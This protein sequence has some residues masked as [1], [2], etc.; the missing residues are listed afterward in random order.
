MSA[1]VLE[2]I[3]A[4]LATLERLV[5][6]PE[7]PFYYGRDLSCVTDITETLEEVD[8]ASPVAVVQAVA[9]RYLTER[10]SLPDDPNYGF[11][12][13]GFLNRATPVRELSDVAG[14]ARLEALKDD[15]V[16]DA[17]VVV[18]MP[19]TSEIGVSVTLTLVDPTVDPI[20]FTLAL[21]SSDVIL[22]IEAAG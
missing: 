15:R 3:A 12:I 5:P 8:P 7:D 19:S 9:R 20:S 13:R 16:E 6:T 4:E 1:I 22:Q 14:Q 18:S 10:G 21:T 11:D 2:A 17:Q